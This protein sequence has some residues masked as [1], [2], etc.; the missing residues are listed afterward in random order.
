[1]N[2]S[3]LERI[4]VHLPELPESEKVWHF[5]SKLKGST[6]FVLEQHN[7]Q[8]LSEAFEMAETVERAAHLSQGSGL[9]APGNGRVSRFALDRPR[10]APWSNGR[11][12]GPV[13]MELNAM[14]GERSG[15]R[16]PLAEREKQ[17]LRDN[18]GCFYCR[19]ANA[20]H[21]SGQCPRR[22]AEERRR[23]GRPG[24]GRGRGR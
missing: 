5:K 10:S 14:G 19:V 20:G 4:L 15:A 2:R 6:R 21:Y 1:M 3:D 23:G 24:N 8:T 13:P 17:E 9:G 18:Q 11:D 12:Q 7:P 22:P 16:A